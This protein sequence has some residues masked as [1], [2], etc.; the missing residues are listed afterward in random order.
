MKPN[1]LRLL[2]VSLGL[3]SHWSLA[4]AQ[5]VRIE[6][7]SA[8]LT[9]SQAAAVEFRR[10]H[11]S[12]TVTVG[13]SGSGGAL[14]KLC[15]SEVDLVHSARP[16]LKAEIE[17]CR[18][19]DVQFIELPLAFDAV[20]VVVN[21]KNGFVRS[22]TLDELRAMWEESAQ[23]KIVRWNQVNP[24][25]PDA[26]LK[27]LAPDSQFDGS[28]YFAAAVLGAGKA[29]RRDYMGSVDDNVLLQGMVR[30]VNTVAYLPVATYLENRAKVRAVSIASS[31]GAEAVA[32]SLEAIAGGKYQPLS[33]PLFLYVNARSLSRPDAASFVEFYAGNAS[34]LV[35]GADYV[36]LAESAYQA[37]QNRLRERTTGS[38]W[39]GTVQV[40]LS[41]QELQR[42]EAL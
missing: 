14:G 32:P 9:I 31:A 19:A 7:S 27:L 13:L 12:V 5:T 41:V 26:P 2:V 17:A 40:G 28:N 10:G 35:K 21:P 11:S 22:L 16:I 38:V 39:D 33:R 42:R 4:H 6:G 24:R 23:G 29:T 15:R 20:A 18:N 3:A 8:G 37:G 34:R 1:A 25:F 30:D 36:P